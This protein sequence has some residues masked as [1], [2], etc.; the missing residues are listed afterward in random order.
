MESG[1]PLASLKPAVH[2][3]SP[4]LPPAPTFFV[5]HRTC[6][7]F[8]RRKAANAGRF[9]KLAAFAA[10][11][12]K[13]PGRPAYVSIRAAQ[14]AANSSKCEITRSGPRSDTGTSV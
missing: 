12:R 2:V 6:D 4:A 14:A 9:A 1:F 8:C 5:D 11:A 3:S 7:H 10:V 13:V